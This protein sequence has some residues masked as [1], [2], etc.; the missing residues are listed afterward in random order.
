MSK[1]EPPEKAR[2]VVVYP[3]KASGATAASYMLAM[4]RSM[5]PE[6]T[7]STGAEPDKLVV[8]ARPKDHEAIKST[9]EQIA[10][11]EPPETA[12]RISVYTLETS[13]ATSATGAI[14]T[15][16]T[17]FPEAKFSAGLEAGQIIAWARPADH[18]QIA[19]AI[20]DMSKKEPPEKARTV[21]VYPFKRATPTSGYYTITMLRSLF[22]EAQFSTGASRTSWSSWPAP[23][24]T[25]GSRPRSTRSWRPT[26][27]RPPGT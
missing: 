23:R 17:M 16:T 25:R 10:A 19:Q 12:R 20:E 5:F 18:Q 21:V 22:P 2:K 8:L 11:A 6:A 14:T 9:V 7:F 13:G 4:L 24:T 1:K 3:F 15:L 27:P 26:R